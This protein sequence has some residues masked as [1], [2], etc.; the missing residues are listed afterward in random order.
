M[1]RECS[2]DR[3]TALNGALKRCNKHVNEVKIG[4]K[5]QQLIDDLGIGLVSSDINTFVDGGVCASAGWKANGIHCGLAHKALTD[6]EEKSQ[7]A[8]NALPA[9][10][11]SDLA[12]I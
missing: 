1:D 9:N 4:A 11:K 3:S 7:A 8:N 5:L 10:K 6:T 2:E 12:M